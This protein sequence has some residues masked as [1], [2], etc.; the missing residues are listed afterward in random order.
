M[1]TPNTEAE[2]RAAIEALVEAN[3]GVHCAVTTEKIRGYWS[4]KCGDF[5]TTKGE[6]EE[7]GVVRTLLDKVES[8]TGR[9]LYMALRHSNDAANVGREIAALEARLTTLR[10]RAAEFESLATAELAKV[11]DRKRAV[12]A[13]LT[14]K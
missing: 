8:E 9:G 11:D 5:F 7:A 6:R 14:A 10:T 13:V 2:V 4:A 1:K 3:S 12:F